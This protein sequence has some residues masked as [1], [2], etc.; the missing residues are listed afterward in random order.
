M[1]TNPEHYIELESSQEAF[2]HGLS[3]S[4]SNLLSLVRN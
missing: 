1:P 2:G 3:C 4:S